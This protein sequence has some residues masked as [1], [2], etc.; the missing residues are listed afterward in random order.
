MDPKGPSDASFQEAT[1]LTDYCTLV[2]EFRLEDKPGAG[3][4]KENENGKEEGLG[5]SGFGD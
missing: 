3:K 1:I 4:R 5:P 2:K